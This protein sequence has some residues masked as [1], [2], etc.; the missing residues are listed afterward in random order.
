M[1]FNLFFNVLQIYVCPDVF[2]LFIKQ[3]Q[4]IFITGYCP[5]TLPFV[6]IAAFYD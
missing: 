1:T 6:H 5:N 3:F 4:Y 2:Y